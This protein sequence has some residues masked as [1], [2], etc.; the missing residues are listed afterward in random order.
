MCV[1]TQEVFESVTKAGEWC[2]APTTNISAVCKGKRRTAKGYHWEYAPVVELGECAPVIE[3]VERHTD[4][5]AIDE[6][7]IK[8]LLENENTDIENDIDDL[9][10][11][12]AIAQGRMANALEVHSWHMVQVYQRGINKLFKERNELLLKWNENRKLIKEIKQ[13][14][15]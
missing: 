9:D 2:G 10:V 13:I 8:T 6:L 15:E 7:A 4:D 11:E 12:I 3:P 14:F 1:E 5:S